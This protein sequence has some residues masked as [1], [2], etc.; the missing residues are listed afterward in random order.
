MPTPRTSIHERAANTEDPGID[1]PP[2]LLG[3]HVM[4][5]RSVNEEAL[6]DASSKHPSASVPST[7]QRQFEA[8][9]GVSSRHLAASVPSTLQRQVQS[10]LQRQC[11]APYG[12]SSR[13]SYSV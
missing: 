4:C 3:R 7:L 13:A 6:S 11:E 2:L 12:V 9:C 10:T 8:P 1:G 5:R